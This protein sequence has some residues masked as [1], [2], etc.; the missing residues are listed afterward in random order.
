M[1][2]GIMPPANVSGECVWGFIL[3][4]LIECGFQFIEALNME[5]FKAG[6]M[7]QYMTDIQIKHTSRIWK[8]KISSCDVLRQRVG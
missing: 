5:I 2:E 1:V 7:G 4:I 8:W 3:R 6:P